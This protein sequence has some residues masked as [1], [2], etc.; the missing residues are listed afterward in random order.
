MAIPIKETPVLTG[1]KA[2]DFIKK[3]EKISQSPCDTK[4]RARVLSVYDR[5]KKSRKHGL[6]NV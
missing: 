3:A 2:Y 6:V 1:K 5:V 4:E